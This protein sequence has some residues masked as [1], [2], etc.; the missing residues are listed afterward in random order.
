[1]AKNRT[2]SQVVL[3]SIDCRVN[4]LLA[5]PNPPGLFQLLARTQALILYHI[6]RV[7]DGDIAA[8]AAA[9]R[10]QSALEDSAMDLL[11]HVDFNCPSP[12]KEPATAAT[13]EA[14]AAVAAG[15]LP[16]CPLGSTRQ[17][18]RDWIVQESGRR[19]LLFTFFFLQ[20]YRVIS[21]QPVGGCDGRLGLC[22]SFTMSASLW[23]AESPL[24]FARAWYQGR[25]L[26]VENTDFSVVLSQAKAEDV[27]AYGR[28]IL[29]SL[30]GKDEAEV[31][32]AARGGSLWAGGKA[33]ATQTA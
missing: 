11:M 10:T 12:Q 33:A 26:I 27:D 14:S 23:H 17:F 19:T 2:N 18:W 15:Q 21:G 25:H 16:M 9:E 24:A 28:I 32:F 1:M 7:F 4:D 13:A 22:H 30:I 6:I 31:W 20:A 29:T 5:T 8:R 3:R